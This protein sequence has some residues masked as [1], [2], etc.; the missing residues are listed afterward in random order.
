MQMRPLRSDRDPPETGA[1]EAERLQCGRDHL[2]RHARF[3]TKRIVEIM[4]SAM[5][6]PTADMCNTFI[7][8][9]NVLCALRPAS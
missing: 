7:C 9:P 3:A 4:I 5:T 8:I 2:S 6:M 1:T